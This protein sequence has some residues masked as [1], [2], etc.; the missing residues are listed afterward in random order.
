[1][2]GYE[3]QLGGVFEFARFLAAESMAWTI[4][5]FGWP[6]TGKT[7]FPKVLAHQLNSSG[8]SVGLAYIR[9][10]A[11]TA[12]LSVDE[13]KE[14]LASLEDFISQRAE[15]KIIVFDELDALAPSRRDNPALL[16]LSM[17]AMDFLD[18]GNEH[19]KGSIIIGVTNDPEQVEPAVRSR[20]H[21]SL[22]F[23][24]PE[25]DAIVAMLDH[26]EIPNAEAV[27]DQLWQALAK[28]GWRAT[29]RSVYTGI[30]L[31]KK[32][33][34]ASL[35]DAD[36]AAVA[37]LLRQHSR[38]VPDDEFQRYQF[39]NRGLIGQSAEFLQC[40][41]DHADAKTNLQGV[42]TVESHAGE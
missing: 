41:I 35:K 11:L 39:T 2:A 29:G 5:G 18:L 8:M 4:M 7:I 10:Q 3:K 26:A 1:M 17:W 22:Y 21:C 32:L 14:R 38:G 40:W 9:C 27:A 20:L 33:L 23:E 13:V 12:R 37:R 25:M 15:P 19:L 30:V 36:P 42:E 31:V 6:G 34:G 28:E 16:R 24:L